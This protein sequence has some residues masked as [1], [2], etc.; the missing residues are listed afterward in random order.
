M[1]KTISL[2]TAVAIAGSMGVTAVAADANEPLVAAPSSLVI[3][4][5]PLQV[6][7]NGQIGRAHF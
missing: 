5:A 2:L 6:T 7:V 3:A 4:E 1:R